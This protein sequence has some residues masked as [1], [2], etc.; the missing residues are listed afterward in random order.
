MRGSFFA[1][2]LEIVLEIE[3]ERWRQ[4]ESVRG[5]LT[6]RHRGSAAHPLAGLD[7]QL[8]RAQLSAVKK[9]ADGAFKPIV[10]HEISGEDR[11]SVV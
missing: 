11:K 1:K 7:V 3:G 6:L 10:S 5:R 8:C 4:G 9:K 2:P